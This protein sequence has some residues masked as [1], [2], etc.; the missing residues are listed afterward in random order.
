MLYIISLPALQTLWPAIFKLSSSWEK[1]QTESK[2]TVVAVGC[3]Y[4]AWQSWNCLKY[5]H[6]LS[7]IRIRVKLLLPA[8]RGHCWPHFKVIWNL[9]IMSSQAL[10]FWDIGANWKSSV[11]LFWNLTFKD[12]KNV[13]VIKIKWNNTMCISVAYSIHHPNWAC[14]N[15][16][17]IPISFPYQTVR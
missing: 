14:M 1:A 17:K 2:T 10:T 3:C 6:R 5:I 4:N 12:A 16:I 15:Q 7:L 8:I 9:K 11:L 13:S